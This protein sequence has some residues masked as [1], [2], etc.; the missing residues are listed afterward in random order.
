MKITVLGAV[1]ILAIVLA[2]VFLIE[3]SQKPQN[4]GSQPNGANVVN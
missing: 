2:I 1:E 3:Q 4:P